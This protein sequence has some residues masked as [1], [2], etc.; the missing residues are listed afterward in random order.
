MLFRCDRGGGWPHHFNSDP[1]LG[2]D[3]LKLSNPHNPTALK[4]ER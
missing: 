4:G 2:K 3:T 1:S